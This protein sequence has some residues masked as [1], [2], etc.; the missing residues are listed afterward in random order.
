[1][2]LRVYLSVNAGGSFL[3]PMD[4]I[5]FVLSD[6]S[7]NDYG[8]R[9]L[10]EG[11]DLGR[12][13]KNPVMLYVH[14]RG[15]ERSSGDPLLPIGRWENV[16]K[17]NNKLVADAVFD[18]EDEFSMKVYKKVKK[19][20]LNTASIHFDIIELSE[21]ANLM[22][23]GQTMPTITKSVIKEVSIAD[24]P[25]NANAV[26]LN[27]AGVSVKLGLQDSN[28]EDLNKLFS[29]H[30]PTNQS[31]MKNLIAKFNALK[32]S[33]PLPESATEAEVM[34]ALDSVINKSQ[35][36]TDLVKTKDDEIT[37]LKTD[38]TNLEQKVADAEKQAKIDKATA[39]VDG[40]VQAK[41]ISAAQ[42]DTYLKLAN[43]D[44]DA[45]KEMLDGLKGFSGTI[46][47]QL[48]SAA[49]EDTDKLAAE[50]DKLHK[51]GKLAS[52][53]ESKP[54]EFKKLFNAKFG[55]DPK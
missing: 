55:K 32:L 41:K 19:G 47:G 12:F 42:K 49:E 20:I 25:G 2:G 10:T 26:K 43:A 21:D 9:V 6:D 37:A 53:K 44:Y 23:Q 14:L 7:V 24:I 51:S 11:I 39:L 35:A 1:M 33:A 45:T 31:S 13:L 16:R 52:L 8:F 3:L 54:D 40:A 38:K 29:N 17:E 22:L 4:K 34:V 5:T 36:L 50:Y 48:S 30:K 18:E 46:T 27:Y 28:P 15:F